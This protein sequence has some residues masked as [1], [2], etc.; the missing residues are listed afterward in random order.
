M[1][2]VSNKQSPLEHKENA[3]KQHGWLTRYLPILSWLPS[4]QRS[5]LRFDL[6]AGATVWAVIV[7]EA[8]AYSQLAGVP[9][10]AGLFAAPFLL[11][12]YALFG[13]SRQLMV[14]ATSASAV[15]LASTV[16]V[17]A[18]GG[19]D[20]DA[21]PVGGVTLTAGTGGGLLWIAR[22]GLITKFLSE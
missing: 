20:K 7:P 8:V 18:G 11:L 12:G 17:L 19:P 2:E 22:P 3:A 6:I 4:Y 16:A 10:Q 9:P 21:A 14:G 1:A 13:S 5:W 15:M